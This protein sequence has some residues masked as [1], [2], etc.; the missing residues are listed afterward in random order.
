MR[1]RVALRVAG[2]GHL[3]LDR[4]DRGLHPVDDVG[5]RGGT[6]RR[7]LGVGD[8]ET[9]REGAGLDDSGAD[10]DRGDGAEQGGAQ[11]TAGAEGGGGERHGGSVRW[12]AAPGSPRRLA[13]D[14]ASPV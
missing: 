11:F 3:D 8:G 5:E 4:D 13:A 12:V 7:L 10:G 14:N 9:R 1:L 2:L 6:G